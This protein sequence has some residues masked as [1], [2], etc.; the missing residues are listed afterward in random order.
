MFTPVW[1]EGTLL[2]REVAIE[3]S[4]QKRCCLEDRI[5]NVPQPQAR[6]YDRKVDI[7]L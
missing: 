7:Q 4:Q 5:L 1:V 2:R 6:R 3:E